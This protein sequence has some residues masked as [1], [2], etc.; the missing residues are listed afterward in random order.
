MSYHSPLTYSPLTLLKTTFM[1]ERS[2]A[3]LSPKSLV[4]KLNNTCRRALEGAA[5]LCLSNTHYNIEIEH[6]L[7]KLLEPAE[8]DLPRIFRHYDVVLLP[9][10][11]GLPGA[12][13]GLRPATA[14][15]RTWSAGLGGGMPDA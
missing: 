14:R 6:W 13:A 1:G 5:G 4:S 8:S 9:A 10:F 15:R 7:I 11:G 2:V 3:T 12:S